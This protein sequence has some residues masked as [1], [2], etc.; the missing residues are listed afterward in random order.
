M[1]VLPTTTPYVNGLATGAA[2]AAAGLPWVYEV[3]GV[4][5]E[6]WA[7]GGST[8]VERAARRASQRFELMRAKE[9][10]VATYADAVITL[11]ETM[12]HHLIDGGVPAE[13]ITVIPNSVSEAVVNADTTRA[14]S[15][16]RAGL[17]LPEGG[18]WVGTAASIV[19][20]EGLD[21]LVDAVVLARA[22][23]VDLRLLIAGGCPWQRRSTISLDS[24]L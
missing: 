23:G 11:G 10:E 20:Y 5:E 13:K 14:P 22:Q 1:Q 21:D 2:A 7:A 16:V 24:T 6:T 9:I 17:G 12:R 4:L 15:E 8:S 3:R 18:V 19:G